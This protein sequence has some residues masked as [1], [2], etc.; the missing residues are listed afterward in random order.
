MT[1]WGWARNY[2]ATPGKGPVKCSVWQ[3][4]TQP[5]VCKFSNVR[6]LLYPLN[7]IPL[8]KPTCKADA[9]RSAFWKWEMGLESPA[10][11]PAPWSPVSSPLVKSPISMQ[12][13]RFSGVKHRNPGASS[14]E[15]MGEQRGRPRPVLTPLQGLGGRSWPG[16]PRG[17][18]THTFCSWPEGRAHHRKALK[19]VRVSLQLQEC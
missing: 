7:K 13:R 6:E 16:R 1:V 5:M 2:K 18:W 4:S 19:A 10:S 14:G 11:L 9:I 17:A 12:Q 3:E 8:G 15:E